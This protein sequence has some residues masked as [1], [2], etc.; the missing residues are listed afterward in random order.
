MMNSSETLTAKIA[1]ANSDLAK[2]QQ[3]VAL[4]LQQLNAGTLNKSTL[5]T[6]LLELQ[7]YV[8]Q[9]SAPVPTFSN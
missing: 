7:Q 2:A 9:L 8:S 6:G 3:E 4:L 1:I 5:Q